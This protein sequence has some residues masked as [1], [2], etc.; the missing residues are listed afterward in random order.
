MVRPSDSDVI[1]A[2]ATAA[3]LPVSGSFAF[4][5]RIWSRS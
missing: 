4:R 3:G 5:G 2:V 1:A